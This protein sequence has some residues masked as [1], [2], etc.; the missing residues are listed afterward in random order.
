MKYGLEPFGSKLNVFKLQF[1]PIH[2][3]FVIVLE[4]YCI[5]MKYTRVLQQK[6]SASRKQIFDM[7]SLGKQMIFQ[8]FALRPLTKLFISLRLFTCLLCSMI[9]AC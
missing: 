7:S 3:C 2:L 1:H 5:R 8:P 6:T 9:F 4:F